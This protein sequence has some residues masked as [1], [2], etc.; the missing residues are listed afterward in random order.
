MAGNLHS[1][2]D[3]HTFL[4]LDER[5]NLAFIADLAAV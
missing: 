5:A 2:A 3:M 4:D 1:L